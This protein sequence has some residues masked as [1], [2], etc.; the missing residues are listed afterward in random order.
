MLHGEGTRRIN[1][2]TAFNG[3]VPGSTMLMRFMQEDCR[4]WMLSLSCLN[5]AVEAHRPCRAFFDAHLRV[6]TEATREH[7]FH[8]LAGF[9]REALME[10]PHLIFVNLLL[11]VS[12]FWWRHG[13]FRAGALP[14]T[15]RPEDAAGAGCG[16]RAAIHRC[17][18]LRRGCAPGHAH[19]DFHERFAAD[20][21]G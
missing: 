6:A 14:R 4:R 3:V 8:N 18:V 15:S 21:S 9:A 20:D 16:P 2:G 5:Q 13:G 7:L 10:L 1:A 17:G 11:F 19:P 12:L